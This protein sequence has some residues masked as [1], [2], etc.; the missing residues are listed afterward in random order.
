[1]KRMEASALDQE[2]F[3]QLQR[4]NQ[5]CAVERDELQDR[6]LQAKAE[7]FELRRILQEAKSVQTAYDHL[8]Q[9]QLCYNVSMLFVD[10]TLEGFWS[11]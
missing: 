11:G 3:D 7:T 5:V 10:S 1:M 9:V 6:L 8:L 4:E 2:F